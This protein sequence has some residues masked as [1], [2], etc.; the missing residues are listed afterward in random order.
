MDNDESFVF[1]GAH[2]DG[3][4]VRCISTNYTA[5]S[6]N[7]IE[8]TSMATPHVAGVAALAWA[9]NASSTV[10]QVRTALLNG[11]DAIASLAG[12]TVTGR[13]LNA[14]GTLGLI[15]FPANLSK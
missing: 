3:V 8:G 11:G 7:E 5:N 12:T 9:K 13:R 15:P 14:V 4:E 2:I 6:Y 10:A 1:D